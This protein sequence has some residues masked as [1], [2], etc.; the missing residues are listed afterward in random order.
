MSDA[1]L[2]TRLDRMEYDLRRLVVAICGDLE[3]GHPG[4]QQRIA[5]AETAHAECPARQAAEAG[6]RSWR[7]GNL[8]GA[9]ALGLAIVEGIVLVARAV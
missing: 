3:G 7:V 1:E 5:A 6:P 2:K 8:I 4:L 9:V